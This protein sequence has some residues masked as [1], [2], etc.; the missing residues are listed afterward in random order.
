MTW[1]TKKQWQKQ[2]QT[3]RQ[4]HRHWQRKFWWLRTWIHDNLCFL[5]IKSDTGQHSQ[6]LRSFSHLTQVL[7]IIVSSSSRVTGRSTTGRTKICF[8]WLSRSSSLFFSC[9]SKASL[10]MLSLVLAGVR[11]TG[12]GQQQVKRVFARKG[13][14]YKNICTIREAPL[15]QNR[16][17]SKG[18]EG[19]VVFCLQKKLPL[20]ASQAALEVMRVT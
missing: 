12:G 19:G 18:G 1:P 16:W 7:L 13:K 15:S 6:F 17:I 2:T 4:W 3:Q 11:T 5:I 20:I 9:W 8:M 14:S 10:S